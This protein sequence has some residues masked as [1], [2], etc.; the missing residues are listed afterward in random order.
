MIFLPSMYE[1]K[2]RTFSKD[3]TV[4]LN[5]AKSDFGLSKEA[6]NEKKDYF[7]SAWDEIVA[8]TEDCIKLIDDGDDQGEEQID[9]LQDHLEILKE[10]RNDFLT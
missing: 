10:K 9:E 1:T 2:I 8:S 7:E 3:L 4:A 6:F 5:D